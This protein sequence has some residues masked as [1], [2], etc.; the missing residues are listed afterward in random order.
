MKNN[1][2]L[3]WIYGQ[4]KIVLYE[5]DK[6]LENT[7]FIITN[8]SQYEIVFTDKKNDKKIKFIFANKYT[9][10]LGVQPLQNISLETKK[11][12]KLLSEE[13]NKKEGKGA[14]RKYFRT[15]GTAISRTAVFYDLY[16][17]YLTD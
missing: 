11:G 6:E 16:C 9:Y 5:F 8:L 17:R 4:A 2:I 13:V 10:G 15:R 1:N 14:F 7:T 12:I 3:D